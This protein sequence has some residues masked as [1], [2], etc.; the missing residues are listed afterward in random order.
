M[1]LIQYFLFIRIALICSSNSGAQNNIAHDA[2]YYIL[3]AQNGEKWA[4]DDQNIDKKLADF[5]KRNGG[6]AP[7]ILYIL[8][9]DVGFGDLVFPE[10]NAVRGYKT[11]SINK[12]ATES[13]RFVRMYTEPS[14]K[15][16]RGLLL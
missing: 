10:L 5:R 15:P 8:L 4:K 11:P 3:Q 7:N 16:T 13:M 9:D 6:K 14:C 2:E 12:L 1:K